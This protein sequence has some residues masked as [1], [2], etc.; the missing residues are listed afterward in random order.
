M[1]LEGDQ[2]FPPLIN[3]SEE[4][5]NGRE[6][7]PTIL[8]INKRPQKSGPAWDPLDDR[9]HSMNFCNGFV[10]GGRAD[11]AGLFHAARNLQPGL[12]RPASR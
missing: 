10:D 8:A 5:A 4:A 6:P 11:P 12:V 7:V 3:A 1:D 9:H 2:P